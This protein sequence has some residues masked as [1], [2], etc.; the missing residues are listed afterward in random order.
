MARYRFYATP[1][2]R[3]ICVSSYA[4]RKVRGVAICDENDEYDLE[5]GKALAQARVDLEIAKRRVKRA[6]QKLNE[7]HEAYE[8]AGV[9]V[10]AMQDY[11]D[12]AVNE[13]F[14]AECNL[15]E[16]LDQM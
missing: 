2:P 13:Q 8:A 12:E 4:G 16:L 14:R 10:D 11:V 1:G 9:R 3:V 15:T 7:A 6:N 5:K